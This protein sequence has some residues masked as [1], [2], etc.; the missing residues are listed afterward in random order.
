MAPDEN[1]EKKDDVREVMPVA[2][3]SPQNSGSAI[4]PMTTIQSEA[5][6]PSTP[7]T[8]HVF[9]NNEQLVEQPAGVGGAD[10]QGTPP[11][12]EG[13]G[14]TDAELAALEEELMAEEEGE[15]AQGT[16]DDATTDE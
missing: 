16:S 2:F 10:P 4:K 14:P 8:Q 5:V 15:S 7:R 12:P 9:A 1:T 6:H 11:L 3:L 13:E